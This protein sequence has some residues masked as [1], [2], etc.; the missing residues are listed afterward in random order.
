M[1]KDIKFILK[2]I[3]KNQKRFL[4]SK[5]G[6]H[7][8]NVGATH[9]SKLVKESIDYVNDVFDDYLQY[10]KLDS[11]DLKDKV[12]LEIGPGDNFGNALLFLVHG[13]KKVYLLDKFY[14]ERN[15]EQQY[16]IY[17]RLRENLTKEQQSK[18]DVALIFS[19]N[20]FEFNKEKIEYIYGYGIEDKKNTLPKNYFDIIVSRAVIQEISNT[21][22]VFKKMHRL[23]KMNG[24]MLH[25]IDLRDYGTFSKYK[26]HQLGSLQF[27]S[28]VYKLMTNHSGLPNRRRINHYRNLLKQFNFKSMIYITH[29][30]GENESEFV[31]HKLMDDI[32]KE[33]SQNDI[34]YIESSKSL[35]AKEFRKIPT[36]DLLISGIFI[37]AIKE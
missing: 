33:I 16:R 5:L 26:K 32:E 19:K 4:K 31:P 13:A 12:I 28:F 14:S 21:V 24:L 8:S 2:K 6:N 34:D 25:K 7:I 3:I 27:N 35:L 22:K 11:T 18:F 29:L 30:F 17:K 1:F 20:S 37:N 23:L 10:G 9:K 15:Q 36:T